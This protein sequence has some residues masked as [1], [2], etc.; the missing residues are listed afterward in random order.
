MKSGRKREQM[1]NEQDNTATTEGG[2]QH[3]SRFFYFVCE[4]MQQ[5]D[6]DRE[7]DVEREMDELKMMDEGELGPAA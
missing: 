7:R 2:P 3:P 6:N 1:D 5:G 4:D